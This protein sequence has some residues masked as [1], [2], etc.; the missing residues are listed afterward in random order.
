M[1][2]CRDIKTDAAM[3][4]A[5][6]I[7]SLFLLCA[8]AAFAGFT[9]RK[10]EYAMKKAST[11]GKKVAFVFYQDYYLPNCPTCVRTVD[12][13]NSAIKKAIPRSEV[14]VIEIE[15][16]DKD[17][18]KLPSAVTA[19]GPLPRIVVTDAA[20]E[21]VLAKLDGAPDRDKSKVFKGEVESAE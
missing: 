18:D 11:S 8:S 7:T 17:M 10:L 3:R 5:F 19:N 13:N 14:V 21:K 16:G 9:E 6:A 4:P 15:K 1:I 2:I 12:A 20:C